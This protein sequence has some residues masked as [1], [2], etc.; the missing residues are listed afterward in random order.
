MRY[1][2]TVAARNKQIHCATTNSPYSDQ[3]AKL[4]YDK[5]NLLLV[6]KYKLTAS[7]AC[8]ASVSLHS[9]MLDRKV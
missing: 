5:V 4:S 2:G 9:C 6:A 8:F 3:K 1:T 7:E